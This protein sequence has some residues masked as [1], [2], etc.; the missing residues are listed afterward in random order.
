MKIQLMTAVAATTLLA[1]CAYDPP[2]A[3]GIPQTSNT[4][5]ETASQNGASCG[6]DEQT[7]YVMMQE[8]RAAQ[9]YAKQQSPT[10]SQATASA[11]T[12][13]PSS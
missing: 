6:A 7:H 4:C 2:F 8:K 3:E 13:R 9:Y 5:V 12:T 11:P 1:G 10:A